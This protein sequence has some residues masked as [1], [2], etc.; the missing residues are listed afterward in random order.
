[1]AAAVIATSTTAAPTA[2]TGRCHHCRAGA[3]AGAA[4]AGFERTKRASPMCWSRALTSRSRQRAM[5]ARITGGVEAGSAEKSM[6]AR[7]TAAI[8]SLIVSA[9]NNCRP[10]SISYN[11]TPNAQMSARRSTGRPL[12]CSGDMYAAVPRITPM[13]VMAG[14]VIVGPGSRVPGPGFPESLGP[15]VPESR[16]FANPKS[17][18]FTVPSS[19]TLMLAG[20]RSRWMMPCSCAA[21]SASAIWRAIAMTSTS[22]IPP[23]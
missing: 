15:G 23:G 17:S 14:E 1:M 16:A 11:T 7:N 13:A 6:S 2:I 20:F 22:G 8:V 19:R 10:V 5:S 9:L 3:A 21:S 4:A 18:T 12:A